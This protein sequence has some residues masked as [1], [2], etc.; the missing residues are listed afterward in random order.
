MEKAMEKAMLKGE[1]TQEKGE[2]LEGEKGS[3]KNQNTDK[4]LK[5][6]NS[7]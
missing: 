1:K 3:E 5:K 2:G 6:G 7:D 4:P